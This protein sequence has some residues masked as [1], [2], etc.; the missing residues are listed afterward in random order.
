MRAGLLAGAIA[1]I[2]AALAS[3]PLHAPIDIVFNSVTVTVAVLVLGVISALAWN[4]FRERILWYVGLMAGLFVTVLVAAF[5]GDTVLALDRLV[6]FVVP[7]AAIAFGG[8]AL[9]TPVLAAYFDRPR[10]DDH[11]LGLIGLSPVA[12]AIIALALGIGLV[13][14]GDAASG[15]LS[16]PPPP[17]ATATPPPSPTA[18][19]DGPDGQAPQFVIGE[20]SEITFTVEEELG[21][22]PVR[23]DAVISSKTLS[24][25]A[26]LDGRP[27]VVIL[28]LHSLESDQQFR[29]R[30]MR[31]R[32]FGD[33][34]EAEVTIAGL[35]DLPQSFFD[36]QEAVGKLSGSLRI[37]QTV[38]PLEFDVTAR[39][40]GQKISILGKTVFTW[41][42]LILAK[43]TASSV[44]Y[45]A[46]EVRV[47]VLLI[48]IAP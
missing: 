19:S 36:G 39:L 25:F 37:G 46:D 16:L 31:D 22:S 29:D 13:G 24:G 18:A 28:D 4:R 2:A 6:S 47:Q 7:L 8:A 41:E 38:T 10:P 14:Q 48:A 17:A 35:P 32:M 9:L 27:S 45:L 33:T 1:A 43:P 21:R 26:N 3:L 5:I 40:D 30:Y 20:G 15:D 44:V 12:A 34:P 42:Q 11:P 23:F